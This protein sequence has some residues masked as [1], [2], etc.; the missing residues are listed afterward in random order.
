MRRSHREFC[1][2]GEKLSIKIGRETDFSRHVWA[3]DLEL[4]RHSDFGYRKF[5]SHVFSD[6]PTVGR[7]GRHLI[8][9]AFERLKLT[10][11]E[12]LAKQ[13]AGVK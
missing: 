8:R 6:Q 12:D 9:L 1:R 4:W 11:A 13:F 3:V 5:K 7:S 2:N 10:V